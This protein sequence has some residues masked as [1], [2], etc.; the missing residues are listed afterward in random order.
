VRLERDAYRTHTTLHNRARRSTVQVRI[1]A[2]CRWADGQP[3]VLT[4][5]A[6]EKDKEIKWWQA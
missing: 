6:T 3:P 1:A 2:G 4:R 5:Y